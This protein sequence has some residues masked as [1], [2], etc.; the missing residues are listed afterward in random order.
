MPKRVGVLVL[1]QVTD[2]GVSV[3]FDVLRAANAISTRAGR[4]PPFQVEALSPDGRPVTSAAG[5]VLGVHGDFRRALRCDVLLVPGCWMERPEQLEDYLARADVDVCCDLLRRAQRRGLVL[6]ASCSGVFIFAKAGLL[7]GREATTTWWIGP[8]M[9]RRF[10]AVQL[11]ETRSLIREGKL[12]TAGAVFAMADLALAL[13]A[14]AGGP[15]LARQ[16]MRV[17]LLDGHATQ[18]PYMALNQ[19][20][21]EEPVRQAEAWARKHLSESFSIAQLARA[22][23]VSQRTLARRLDESLGLSPIAFVQR[24]RVETAA[25]LLETT[26]SSVEEVAARVGYADAGTVRRLLRRAGVSPRRLRASLKN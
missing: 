8:E 13:V 5:L 26:R 21:T 3:A 25:Q 1:D 23:G 7:D 10:P 9:R 24:L 17:L 12:L 18:G 15:T 6:G 20:A 4:L 16:V 11:D 2:S 14:D 19:L 22:V